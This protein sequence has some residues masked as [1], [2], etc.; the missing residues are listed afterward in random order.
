MIEQVDKGQVDRLSQTLLLDLVVNIVESENANESVKHLRNGLDLLSRQ[1]SLEKDSSRRFLLKQL[2]MLG[3]LQFRVEFLADTASASINQNSAAD[4]SR[5]GQA[6]DMG[7]MVMQEQTFHM[8]TLIH[9]MS[10]SAGTSLNAF[11]YD[12][13]A[14]QALVDLVE[15]IEILLNCMLNLNFPSD[16]NAID[17]QSIAG[18]AANASRSVLNN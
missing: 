1:L 3:L 6:A 11:D 18:P 2:Q 4:G 8:Q 15:K 9:Q 12:K 13:E 14:N 16:Y 17:S 7:T 5:E 10:I